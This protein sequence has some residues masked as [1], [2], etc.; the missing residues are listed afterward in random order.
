MAVAEPAAGGS[1]WFYPEGCAP[2]VFLRWPGRCS[3][4]LLLLLLLPGHGVHIRGL[5]L[6]AGA[7]AHRRAYLLRHLARESLGPRASGRRGLCCTRGPAIGA[8]G[9]ETSAAAAMGW[10]GMEAGRGPPGGVGC[11]FQ[12]PPLV[13]GPGGA[14]AFGGATRPDVPRP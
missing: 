5:L 1:E 8:G 3:A 2:P 7:A 13:P 12:R 14:E 4:L 11:L 9:P 10:D 6:H